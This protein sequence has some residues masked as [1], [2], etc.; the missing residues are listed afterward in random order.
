MSHFSFLFKVKSLLVKIF[1]KTNKKRWDTHEQ[2][3][4][5]AEMPPPRCPC[6]GYPERELL[7]QGHGKTEWPLP[8]A[9]SMNSQHTCYSPYEHTRVYCDGYTTWRHPSEGPGVRGGEET[10]CH[11][12]ALSVPSALS[13]HTPAAAVDWAPWSRG[14]GGAGR[15][16]VTGAVF[17]QCVQLVRV[18]WVKNNLKS[19]RITCILETINQNLCLA[20]SHKIRR[21]NVLEKS[22]G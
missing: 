10:E 20:M 12:R 6:T 7:I 8:K 15:G 22:I 18:K 16:M 5:G 2:T 19:C 11:T 4:V 3:H 14:R 9:R 21:E 13:P 17:V 1:K